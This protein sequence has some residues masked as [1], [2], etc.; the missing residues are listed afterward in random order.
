MDI[1]PGKN[2]YSLSIRI[3]SGGLSLFMYDENMGFL[4]SKH[5]FHQAGMQPT[6]LTLLTDQKELKTSFRKTR[7][8]IE[9]N[10]YSLIPSQFASAGNSMLKLQHPN[11]T[12]NLPVITNETDTQG[13]SVVFA[14]KPDLHKHLNS[15]YPELIPQLHLT[16]FLKTPPESGQV[17][18][19][20]RHNEID[21]MLFDQEQ[22]KLMNSFSIST[23]EDIIYFTLNLYREF[24][25]NRR[26]FPLCTFSRDSASYESVIPA[27]ME[28]VL[29]PFFGN[30]KN[31]QQT[32]WYE[33]YQW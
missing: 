29:Q 31:I 4:S 2:D 3:F 22:W 10:L 32:S 23:A 27:N 26:D 24:G 28:A 5:L 30:I 8:F 16:G 14:I 17:I 9:T 20:A 21:L 11:L 33:N 25:L 1:L 13:M 7:V 18:L 6:D 19:W 15:N 12:E